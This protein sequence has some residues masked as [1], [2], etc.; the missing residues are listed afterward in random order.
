MNEHKLRMI[1][2]SDVS[3]EKTEW[4][5]DEL[6]EVVEDAGELHDLSDPEVEEDREEEEGERACEQSRSSTFHFAT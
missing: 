3:E 4:W 5:T 1:T 6:V 2:E